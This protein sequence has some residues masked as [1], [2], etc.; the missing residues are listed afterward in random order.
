MATSAFYAV[1]CINNTNSNNIQIYLT[2][3][4]SKQIQDKSLKEMKRVS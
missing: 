1:Q 4:E 3:F 2:H